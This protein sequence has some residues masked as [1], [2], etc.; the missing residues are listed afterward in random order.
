MGQVLVAGAILQC[1]HKGTLQMSGG[2]SRLSV[3]GNGAITFGMEAGLSF[4][5][6][7]PGVISPCPWTNPSGVASPC[8]ATIAALAGQ[9]TQLAVGGAPVLLDNAN[10]LA[11]N[12]HDPS[13]TWSVSS[14]GQNLLSAS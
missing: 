5:P 1:S 11:T 7:A 4:A 14:A 12:P 2:D 6:G 9:A 13:A 3:S 8:A 10:G